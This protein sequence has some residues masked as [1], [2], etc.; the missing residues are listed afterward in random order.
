MRQQL[1]EIAVS[2]RLF[3]EPIWHE[4]HRALGSHPAIASRHTCGR[5]SLFLVEALRHEGVAALW[6]SGVPRLSEQGP[7][8]GPYG[9]Y[10]GDRWESHA[11]VSCDAW[12]VDITADQ[13]GADPVV[14]ARAGDSRYSAGERDTTLPAHVAARRK[15]VD[16]LWPKWL[17]HRAASTST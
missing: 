2:A 13:F 8:I 15:A 16:D 11:W 4:W 14:V 12:I 9:F 5:S 3:I 10:A 7:E 1:F 17:A 6:V